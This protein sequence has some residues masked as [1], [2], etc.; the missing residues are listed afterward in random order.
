V[1]GFSGLPEPGERFEVVGDEREARD[2]GQHRALE[3]RER[4]LGAARKKVTLETLQERIME[5]QVKELRIVLKAD[6]F[7]SA[8]ALRDSLEGQSLEEVRVKVVHSGVGAINLSDVLLAQA[9]EAVI[10]G[11][12]VNALT[13]ASSMAEREGIE[14]RTYR[15][16]YSAIDD[17]RSAMLGMLEPER[18]EVKLGKIEVRQIYQIPRVGQVLGCYVLEGKARR[19]A[20]V[21]IMREAK[22]IFTGKIGTLKRFKDDVKEVDA[23]YECGVMIEN[24]PELQVGDIL[25][26][27][28][29]E[30]TARTA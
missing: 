2:I 27:F 11:F 28:T 24:A 19:D 7:G 16:I 30:E 12:H 23:N 18:K 21:R 26:I 22:V 17:I 20:Q 4:L 3:K 1:L 9:S 6:T 25:E 8:E 14:I 5:G 10:V 15:I 29:V 13:D